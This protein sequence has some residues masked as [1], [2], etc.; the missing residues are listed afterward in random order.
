MGTRA[1]FYVGRGKTAEWLGSVAWDGY[2]S[3]LT[4]TKGEAKPADDPAHITNA[5]S[6]ADYRERVRSLLTGRE[7][8]TLP[9]DGWPWPWDD[10]GTTDYAY[11]FD[12]GRVWA[13]N[14]GREWWPANEPT[15]EGGDSGVVEF[16]DMTAVKRV[17]FGNRSG[18]LII[19]GPPLP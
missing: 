14:F 18:L 2:P 9:S 1:D 12:G 11:A 5:T 8:A 19:G 7:D 4:N 17:T 13:S 10:S 15:P 6:E 3:G 16:P